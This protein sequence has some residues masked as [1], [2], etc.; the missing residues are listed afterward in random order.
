M[1]LVCG[2]DWE[3]VV[4]IGSCCQTELW[5]LGGVALTLTYVLLCPIL[6]RPPRLR[7]P[8]QRHQGEEIQTLFPLTTA[9][10][11][12]SLYKV[13]WG[14]MRSHNVLTRGTY[15]C[16]AFL[17]SL[18]LGATCQTGVSSSIPSS[19]S[20][21]PPSS[22]VSSSTSGVSLGVTGTSTGTADFPTLSGYSD[23]GMEK[24]LQAWFCGENL[25]G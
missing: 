23:C 25:N 6:P 20:T 2:G 5:S 19:L 9:A 10:A 16:V 4:W 12:S 1:S 21:Q 13:N 3:E 14:G 22:T 15:T 8:V 17:L 24:F 7:I 18:I 11:H